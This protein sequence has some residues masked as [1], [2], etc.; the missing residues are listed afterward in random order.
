MVNKI[1]VFRDIAYTL[2]FV[3]TFIP[4]LHAQTPNK[5]VGT[6]TD[7]N[8]HAIETA[9]VVLNNSLSTQSDEQG[10]FSI[11]IVK[12]GEYEYH[13]SCLGFEEVRGRAV[14]KGDGTDRLD[15]KLK[16]LALTLQEVR[17]TARQ[18]SMGSHSVIGQ[19][20]IR[21]IQPK[22]V[23]DMLQLLPGAL[24]VNP[25][26]NN[27][28]QANIRE[29]GSDAS[30]AMGT[31]VIL[32]GAPLS[33]DANLQ[34]ISTSKSGARSSLQEDGMNEQTAA[35][36]GIDLRTMGTDNI[37][38]VE[39]IRGIPGVEYGNLTSGVVIVRTKA[40]DSP[41]EVK[42]KTDPFSKLA[43]VGK[44]FNLLKAGMFNVGLDW[45]QSYA[46]TRL[47]YRGYERVTASAAYSK[48]FNS[49][50][51][52]PFTFNA[53]ASFYSNI[54]NY[55]R[56]PQLEQMQLSYKNEN[57]GGRLSIHGGVR[58]GN[59]LTAL[60]YNFSAQVSRTLDTHHNWVSNPDGV[61]T[62]SR[63]SGEAQA[64]FLTK[65]YYSD[66][67]IEG[68]PL[69]LYAQLKTNK[70][71]QISNRNFTNV[72]LGVEY[73]L[74][75][76]NGRGLTFDMSNPPQAMGSQ[77]LRPR[78][79]KEIPSLQTLSAF[80]EDNSVLHFG[81][82]SL[83]FAAGVRFSNLLLDQNKAR[84]TSIVVAEPRVN[85]EYTFLTKQNN[86][87]F[88]RLAVSGGF[89]ISNKMP[90][91]LYLYP[92]KAYFDSNSLSY[93]GGVGENSSL[94]IITTKVIDDTQNPHLRPARSTK[95]ELG[96]NARIGKMRGYV[97]FFNERHRHE[98]GFDSQLEWLNY[99][100]YNVPVGASKLNY[101]GSGKVGY[102]FEGKQQTATVT[103]GN[104]MVTWGR[105]T[106]N[107]RSDKYGIEY[108][109]DF[110]MFRPLR[111]S[112]N[113]DGAWFHIKRKSETTSLNYI[114]K[115]YDYVSVLPAGDGTIRDRVSTNFRFITHIPEVKIIFTTTLQVVW[116]ESARSIY[117]APDGAP[118]YHLSTDGTRY[119]VS[120][121][122]F[123]DRQGKWTDWKR[124]FED[125]PTYRLMS[126]QYLLYAF[127]TDNIEP[128]AM[129]NFRFTKELGQIAELSFMANNF[130]NI[131][132]Y[133][134][135]RHTESKSRM[136]PDS[137]FGAE[138]KLKL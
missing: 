44:G 124:A 38:E 71:I 40:G 17:V 85:M 59:I 33:N 91:L 4:S 28:A 50:G 114:N 90:A 68:I 53:N 78:S 126:D 2:L 101:T 132:K 133:H 5:L 110:G 62:D 43:Y 107:S 42:F 93:M 106:N 118:A 21:H 83:Q 108:A 49:R 25:T 117:E 112:L 122:G 99:N 60:I 54:N 23:A 120:P 36:R 88:D 76:N 20:A 24:T 72:K 102:E 39:V 64:Q 77:T 130:L 96:L 47:R 10:R 113:I 73:R 3:F 81:V 95:W 134:V 18:Q 37:A 34:A 131:R 45:S 84:R 80:V 31:A 63:T 6:V 104:E 116:H 11:P 48:V 138:L 125:D 26:L 66:Y 29:I 35:A 127:K 9:S 1:R 98:L 7:K 82:T 57:V 121:L 79:Y 74:D 129:L 103:P 65:A 14:F 51:N 92:D 32:D 27:L 109:W 56:D 86:G 115:L 94:A 128:W 69:N 15:V 97:T 137:Y 136:H 87:V 19:D 16:P 89:G 67:R 58:L 22:S 135:N 12:S 105:P 55:K 100:I 41:L 123:Y 75:G 111:T 30:N 61:I 13:I 119:V 70:Y 46:D 8:G 52:H